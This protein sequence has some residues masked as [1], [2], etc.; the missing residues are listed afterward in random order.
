MSDKP[1][2]DAEQFTRMMMNFTDFGQ[3]HVRAAA[4][5]G[6]I[7]PPMVATLQG[8]G[9]KVEVWGGRAHRTEVWHIAKDRT[10]TLVAQECNCVDGSLRHAIAAA[11]KLALIQPKLF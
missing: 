5:R 6:S 10:A 8:K 3:W 4:C 2:S 7:A 1:I 11:C 9:G